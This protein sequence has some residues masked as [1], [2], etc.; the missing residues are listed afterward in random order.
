MATFPALLSR[1][2]ID[3]SSGRIAPSCPMDSAAKQN[4]KH[5]LTRIVSKFLEN[6]GSY[7]YRTRENAID[8]TRERQFFGESSEN[9]TINRK[10]WEKIWLISWKIIF[11]K[12]VD[13]FW[14][15]VRE[16]FR[17]CYVINYLL[18]GLLV[19]YREILSPRFLRTDLASSVFTSKPRAYR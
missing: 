8:K 11:R 13:K 10:H 4:W 7:K 17:F 9:L 1:N 5:T 16:Y 3:W 12:I 2:L 19:L 6:I 15:N 18:T 14:A